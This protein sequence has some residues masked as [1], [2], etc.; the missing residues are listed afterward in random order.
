MTTRRPNKLTVQA[1]TLLQKYTGGK[2][3]VKTCVC[4]VSCVNVSVLAEVL[5]IRGL[6]EC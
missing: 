4:P 5:K 2:K 1:D 6:V 3:G